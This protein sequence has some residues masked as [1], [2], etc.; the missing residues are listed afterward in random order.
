M[1]DKEFHM[2][3]LKKLRTKVAKFNKANKEPKTDH[4]VNRKRL[5]KLVDRYSFEVVSIA[6]GLNENTVRQHYRNSTGTALISSYRLDRAESILRD[7]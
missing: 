3:D 5:C 4:S 1:A 7:M 6:T 2:I